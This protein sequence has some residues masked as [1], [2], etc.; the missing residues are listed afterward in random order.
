MTPMRLMNPIAIE[1]SKNPDIDVLS[2]E[3]SADFAPI[4]HGENMASEYL[5]VIN[6]RIQGDARE[7]SEISEKFSSFVDD[8]A[9][10]AL[11]DFVE[12][13]ES[14]LGARGGVS[15]VSSA[16]LSSEPRFLLKLGAVVK[17][18]N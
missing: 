7:I 15:P 1:L 8:L 3:W 11:I 13:V 5:V 4:L 16:D 18:D 6:G 10:S 12:V 2:L 9:K 17:V 14:P